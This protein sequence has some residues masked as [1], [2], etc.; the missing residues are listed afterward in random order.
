MDDIVT[1][2]L[3]LYPNE[4]EGLAILREQIAAHEILND[5]KNFRGHACGSGIVL[6]PDKKAILLIHHTFLDMWLQPG[7]HMEPEELSPQVTAQRETE[8]ETG[9]I[10]AGE[11]AIDGDSTLPIDIDTHYI[12]ANDAKGEPAHY[13]HDFRYVFLASDPALSHQIQ[14]VQAAEW[15]PLEDSRLSNLGKVLAKLREHHLITS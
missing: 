12:P 11:L 6:S 13:H 3:Q 15:V 7:G 2:Y 8:E 14:E 5:R 10:L 1:K 4:A 9:V